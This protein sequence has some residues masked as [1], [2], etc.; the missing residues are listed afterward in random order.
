M[1]APSYAD[2]A[3]QR[4]KQGKSVD[5][6]EYD[7]LSTFN[8]DFNNPGESNITARDAQGAILAGQRRKKK[9]EDMEA[10]RSARAADAQTQLNNLYASLAAPKKPVAAAPGARR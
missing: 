1:P 7:Q 8:Y 6:H 4:A 9:R 5:Q 10:A 3:D 2:W